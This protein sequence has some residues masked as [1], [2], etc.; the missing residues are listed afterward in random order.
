[1]AVVS[2]RPSQVQALLEAKRTGAQALATLRRQPER[3][4][5]TAQIGITVVATAAA[6]FGG[7]S[8]AR[9]LEPSLSGLPMI[10]RHAAQVALALVV[11]LVSYLSL[12]LGELV[13]KSLALRANQTIALLVA[14]PLLALSWFARPVVWLLTASS[15]LVLR[16]FKDRTDFAEARLSREELH[17]IVDEAAKTGTLDQHTSELTARALEFDRLTAADVMVPRNHVVALPLDSSHEDIKR[18]LL[19]EQR[20]RIPVYQ[21]TLD[22]VLG[23]V[24]AKDILP[25]AWEGKLIVLKDVLRPVRIVT[26]STR[27][28]ELLRFMQ[29]ERQRLAIVVDEHGGVVGLVTFEDVVEELV[30]EVFSEHEETVPAVVREAGGTLLVRGDV[31]IRDVNRELDVPLEA[32]GK[33]T[34]IAGLCI[35]L[36]GG[37]IPQRG[38][39]LAANDGTVLVVV[40]A[41]VRSIRRVRIVPLVR[42]SFSAAENA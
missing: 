16:P 36:A 23:Y 29:T 1:M 33:A 24:T 19:E 5:A 31:P 12:V 14:R 7:A 11:A 25:V 22:N 42:A 37:A 21:G 26:E 6:A 34:T 9:H 40:A 4:L 17:H 32:V 38:A 15:N 3:F 41:T 18:C 27:A 8:L 13:P 10:G 39:R 20:S 35:E 2:L 30:G 28:A